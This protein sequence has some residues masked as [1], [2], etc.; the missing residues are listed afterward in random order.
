MD[1]DISTQ[2][3]VAS[4]NATRCVCRCC[5]SEFSEQEKQVVEVERADRSL[6]VQE[7]LLST[8]AAGLRLD[9]DDEP[10]TMPPQE[11]LTALPS[12][13]PATT[14]APPAESTTTT[15]IAVPAPS[16]SDLSLDA[17][18]SSDDVMTVTTETTA[19]TPVGKSSSSSLRNKVKHLDSV[20]NSG[21]ESLP[22]LKH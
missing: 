5:E 8:L 10:I 18:E 9:S 14:V 17:A 21:K 22:V 19:R 2:D 1:F 16:S 4:T 12:S 3:W 7:L 13:S 11:M 6:F 15:A 20:K